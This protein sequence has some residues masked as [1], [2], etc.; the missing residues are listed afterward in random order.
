MTDT[1]YARDIRAAYPVSESVRRS[2]DQLF[3]DACALNRT[4]SECF[5]KM[6]EALQAFKSAQPSIVAETIPVIHGACFDVQDLFTGM[7]PECTTID[8]AFRQKLLN[9]V[10]DQELGN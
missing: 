1:P 8:V 6:R 4:F 2:E 9:W 10:V 3:E 5:G 7:E